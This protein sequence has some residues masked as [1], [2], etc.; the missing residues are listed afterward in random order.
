MLRQLGIRKPL[1]NIPLLGD[2]LLQVHKNEYIAK[3]FFD[4]NKVHKFMSE[5]HL[6]QPEF[7]NSA[8]GSF[9]KSKTK[10]QKFK[11]AGATHLPKKK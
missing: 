10:M 5:M 8:C 7:T 11:E 1:T 6:K 4:W 3:K 9:T 2:I